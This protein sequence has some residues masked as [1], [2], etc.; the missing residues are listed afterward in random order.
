[1]HHINILWWNVSSTAR[2]TLRKTTWCTQMEF[3]ICD[4][5]QT[6]RSVEGGQRKKEG[7]NDKES[8]EMNVC[9]WPATLS[10]VCLC[11]PGASPTNTTSFL[12]WPIPENGSTRS[13]PPS[14]S[15]ND[16][17]TC[18][19]TVAALKRHI[20]MNM[21]NTYT[22]AQIHYNLLSPFSVSLSDCIIQWLV[23]TQSSAWCRLSVNFIT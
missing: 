8:E 13:R 20:H 16:G 11:C 17:L 1:M 14:S 6:D 19:S 22:H 18:A 12:K 15:A 4:D 10:S 7:Q 5:R 23:M 9:H 21:H 2:D 3:N